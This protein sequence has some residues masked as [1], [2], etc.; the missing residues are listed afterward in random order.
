MKGKLKKIL[1]SVICVVLVAA[2]G[3]GIWAFVVQNNADP[4]VVVPFHYV[5]MTEYWGDNQESYGMVTTDRIQT[6]FLSSTQTVTEV[7]VQMGQ[8]VKKGDVLLTFDTTLS[9]LALERERLKVEKLKLDLLD[10]EKRLRE[11][12]NMRPMVIPTPTDPTEPGDEALGEPLQGRYQ[13]TSTQEFDGRSPE[14]SI[15]C[16]L[17]GSSQIDSSLFAVL[18]DTARTYQALNNEKEEA[19]APAPTPS[20]SNESEPAGTEPEASEPIDTTPPETQPEETQPEVSEPE[21]T[22]PDATEPGATEPEPTEPEPEEPE[23]NSFYVIF[24]TTQGDRALAATTGWQGLLVTH[25]PSGQ[26]TFRFFDAAYIKDPTVD[27]DSVPDAPEI[28]FGSGFTASQ[29]AQ[30]RNE[31]EKLI[32][33]LTFNIK[34]AEADYKIKQTEA[35]DGKV[36]AQIDG[37]VVSLLSPEEAQASMQPMLKVSGGGGFY[38]SGSVSEL[39]KDAL[40]IG[41]EVTVNDWYTGMMHTGTIQSVNDYPTTEN[42]YSGMGNPNTS[43]YGFTVFVDGSADM[44]EGNYVSMQ[45]SAGNVSNGIYLENPFLRTEGGRSYV[46]VRNSDGKLE[47][48]YVTTGKSLWGSYTEILSGLTAEDYI[49]FPYGKTVKDGAPAVEGDLSDLYG[50]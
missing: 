7:M 20:P 28:D 41:Q 10:A 18:L 29:I 35:N 32:K 8:E 34:L 50:Y 36:Y 17:G 23:V 16:W 39:T 21:P 45:Y 1:I 27:P 11:I 15:I 4:V 33:E 25:T 6:V 22:E 42:G 13:I 5:G 31:Q 3:L 2:L 37:T 19:E 30:M 26:F 47:K 40:T 46:F 49:A 24:K 48:R 38:I 44:M 9:D 43:Y 12:K 14:K